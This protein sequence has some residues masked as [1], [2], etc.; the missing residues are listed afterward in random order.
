[1]KFVTKK[2]FRKFRRC[3]EKT[4]FGHS[5]VKSQYNGGG[6]VQRDKKML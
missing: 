4:S 6:Q 3:E 1:M 2:K 5:E